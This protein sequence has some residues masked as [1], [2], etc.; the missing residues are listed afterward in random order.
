MGYRKFTD[1]NG[2][3]WE[4]R[5]RTRSEW[6]FEPLP[7]NRER[8]KSVPAPGYEKDPFELSVEELQRLFDSVQPTRSKSK[9]SPFLD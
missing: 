1:N 3:V 5:D 8:P 4:V 9:K 6:D 7:G 2:N